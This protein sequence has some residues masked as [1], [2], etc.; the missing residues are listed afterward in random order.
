[1]TG[2]WQAF[3]GAGHSGSLLEQALAAAFPQWGA[4]AAVAGAGC[5]KDT[6]VPAS[7]RSRQRVS[8][9]VLAW[10]SGAARAV[11]RAP[12][13]VSPVPAVP[14][15]AIPLGRVTGE[16]IR[17]W[18]RRSR[19]TRTHCAPCTSLDV[20]CL[21]LCAELDSHETSDTQ[22]NRRQPSRGSQH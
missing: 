14:K 17:R 6:R 8:G 20:L 2:E 18:P 16:T 7:S 11:L 15:E 22:T 5:D 1:M 13:P 3:P 9:R 4:G 10:L 12:L 19:S 21:R